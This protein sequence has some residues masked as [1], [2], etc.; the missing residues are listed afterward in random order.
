MESG[1]TN[2]ARSEFAYTIWEAATTSVLVLQ[3][4]DRAYISWPRFRTRCK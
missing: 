2:A 4:E 3:S 1:G